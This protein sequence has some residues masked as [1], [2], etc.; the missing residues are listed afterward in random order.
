MKIFNLTIKE[1]KYL[2][3]KIDNKEKKK[4]IETKNKLYQLL[5]N[6]NQFCSEDDLILIFKS[7]NFTFRKKLMGIDKPI[8]NKY[9][10]NIQNKLPKSFKIM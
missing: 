8:K 6:N 4:A 3:D 9:F 7:L 10:K 1:K 5:N 2:W